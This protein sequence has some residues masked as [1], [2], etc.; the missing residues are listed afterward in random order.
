MFCF[1]CWKGAHTDTGV[2]YIGTD[3]RVEYFI[4]TAERC[5]STL[6]VHFNTEETT[7]ILKRVVF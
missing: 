2:R 6:T 7:L 5:D 4:L 3:S 1:F